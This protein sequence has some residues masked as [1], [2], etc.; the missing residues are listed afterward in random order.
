MT[1]IAAWKTPRKEDVHDDKGIRV[2]ADAMLSDGSRQAITPE[3]TKVHVFRPSVRVPISSN[4]EEWFEGF[5]YWEHRFYKQFGLFF[6]GSWLPFSFVKDRVREVTENLGLLPIYTEGHRGTYVRT[7]IVRGEFAKKYGVNESMYRGHYEPLPLANLHLFA[8]VVADEFKRFYVS[9]PGGAFVRVP[10]HPSNGDLQFKTLIGMAGYCDA[11]KRFRIFKMT[12]QEEVGNDGFV[13]EVPRI[14][15]AELADDEVL[16]M[17]SESHH[18]EIRSKIQ[19]EQS[20]MTEDVDLVDRVSLARQTVIEKEIASGSIFGVGGAITRAEV[21]SKY[22]F[23]MINYP[24][25]PAERLEY[26][27]WD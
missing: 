4:D 23:K 19:A 11:T 16:L 10:G 20:A 13:K 18:E 25:T 3:W 17:G 1:L 21:D 24:W 9:Q 22:G 15:I 2:I 6:A 26:D 5:N 14:V 12:P 27:F 7:D 8:Q